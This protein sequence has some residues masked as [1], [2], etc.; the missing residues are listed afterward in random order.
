MGSAPRLRNS[1]GWCATFLRDQTQLTPPPPALNQSMK[2]DHHPKRTTERIVPVHR[3]C[4]SDTR[5]HPS[6]VRSP[7]RPSR[8]RTRSARSSG[9]LPLRHPSRAWNCAGKW[10][11]RS[12]TRSCKLFVDWFMRR[13]GGGQWTSGSMYQRSNGSVVEWINGPMEERTD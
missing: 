2:R 13:G 1:L 7:R 4:R 5:T 3:R 12:R 9:R 8:P 6:S 10:G 11:P